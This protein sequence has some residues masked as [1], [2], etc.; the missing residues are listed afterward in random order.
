MSE[1]RRRL[2]NM[3]NRGARV[4]ADFLHEADTIARAKEMLCCWHPIKESCHLQTIKASDEGPVQADSG[5][6][7]FSRD[8]P[9]PTHCGHSNR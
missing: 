9:L 5:N 1:R 3:A 2:C 8:G 7:K 4:S 6:R